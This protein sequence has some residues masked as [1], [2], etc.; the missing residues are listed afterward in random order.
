MIRMSEMVDCIEDVLK[1]YDGKKCTPELTAEIDLEVRKIFG[2]TDWP[3]SLRDVP[4][5]IRVVDCKDGTFT[6]EFGHEMV[7]ALCVWGK[8]QIKRMRD[9]LAKGVN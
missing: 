5:V 9:G 1:K 2:T 8:E 4:K 3:P 6:V 7:Y